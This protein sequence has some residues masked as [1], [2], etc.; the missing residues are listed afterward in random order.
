MQ[1]E[2]FTIDRDILLLPEVLVDEFSAETPQVLRPAFDALWQACGF[3]RSQNYDASGN[4]T[5]K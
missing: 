4:W 1:P 2:L 3:E 5:V